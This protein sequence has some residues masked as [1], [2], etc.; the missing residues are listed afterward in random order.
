MSNTMT[1]TS[2]TWRN[3]VTDAGAEAALLKRSP[4]T[5]TATLPLITRTGFEITEIVTSQIASL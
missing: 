4:E 1:R 5:G 2:V 3:G